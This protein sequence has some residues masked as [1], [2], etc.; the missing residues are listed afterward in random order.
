M[1]SFILVQGL[2]GLSI[3]V[4]KTQCWELETVKEQREKKIC[5]SPRLSLVHVYTVQILAMCGATHIQ[6]G[7]PFFI[8]TSLETLRWLEVRGFGGSKSS[9]IEDS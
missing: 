2:R 6:D 9:Q 1:D 8:S 3:A 4:G 5:S 7:L